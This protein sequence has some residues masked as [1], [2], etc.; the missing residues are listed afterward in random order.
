MNKDLEN[1]K[2]TLISEQGKGACIGGKKEEAQ[3]KK[4][5]RIVKDTVKVEKTEDV[6]AAVRLQAQLQ[7]GRRR[8][9]R[10][11]ENFWGIVQVIINIDQWSYMIKNIIRI[12]N[13]V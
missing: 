1:Y 3:L 2:E 13:A 12:V 10:M 8:S 9:S 4:L 11:G 7:G 5:I 6:Q